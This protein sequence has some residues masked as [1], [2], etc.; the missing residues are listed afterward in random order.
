MQSDKGISFIIISAC[1]RAPKNIAEEEWKTEGLKK[2]PVQ[3]ICPGQKAKDIRI[4]KLEYIIQRQHSTDNSIKTEDPHIFFQFRFCLQNSNKMCVLVIELEGWH[5]DKKKK[6]IKEICAFL[7]K[8]IE[9]LYFMIHL[10][11][12]SQQIQAKAFQINFINMKAAH[13]QFSLDWCLLMK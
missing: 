8:P 11:Y 10:Q 13:P 6:K 2:Y 7:Y 12:P 5:Y 4:V 3:V 1:E 9:R